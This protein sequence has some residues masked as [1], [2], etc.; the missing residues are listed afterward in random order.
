[1]G[2][3]QIRLVELGYVSAGSDR[4]GWL[5]TGTKQALEDFAKDKTLT[6]EYNSDAVLRALFQRTP[7]TVGI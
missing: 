4:R 5:S 7:V 2:L 1:V 6:G 3:T